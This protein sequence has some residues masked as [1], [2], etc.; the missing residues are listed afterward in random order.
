MCVEI[1]KCVKGRC[2]VCGVGIGLWFFVGDGFPVPQHW[3]KPIFA[4]CRGTFLG[5]IVGLRIVR[6]D[7]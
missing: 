6:R 2:A 7:W 5:L 1:G 4:W 3:K